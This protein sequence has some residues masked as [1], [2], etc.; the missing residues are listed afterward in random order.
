VVRLE[1][2]MSGKVKFRLFQVISV[3]VGLVQ[4]RSG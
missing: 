3:T 4:F 2:V 1:Q